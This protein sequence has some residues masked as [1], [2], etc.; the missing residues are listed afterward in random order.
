MLHFQERLSTGKT[1]STF[2][3]GHKRTQ[4]WILHP[5]CQE[6]EVLIPTKYKDMHGWADCGDGFVGVVKQTNM[7]Y[8]VPVGAITGPAHWV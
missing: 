6:Y 5:Q 4:E 1:I 2:S 3:K 7:L 8:I